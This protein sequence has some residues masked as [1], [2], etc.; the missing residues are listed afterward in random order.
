MVGAPSLAL[1]G[2]CMRLDW[3]FPWRRRTSTILQC[4]AVM[5]TRQGCHLC[6]AAWQVLSEGQR[7]WGFELVAVDVDSAEELVQRDGDCVPVVVI[8]GQ[9][10]FRGRV[11]KVLL[12]RLM[13]AGR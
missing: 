6:D 12:D 13:R 8:D 11:N 2:H 10:R 1:N 5:Y 7:Q 9:V 3:L 4:S